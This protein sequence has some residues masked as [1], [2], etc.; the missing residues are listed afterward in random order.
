MSRKQS[1]CSNIENP[2]DS[3]NDKETVDLNRT[4][5]SDLAHHDKGL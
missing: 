1:F 5:A 2:R 3:Y 4:F